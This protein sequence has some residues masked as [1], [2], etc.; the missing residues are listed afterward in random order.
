MVL[1]YL[2]IRDAFQFAAARLIEVA[3]QFAVAFL[4]GSEPIPQNEPL[5][6]LVGAVSTCG[7][8]PL[9]LVRRTHPL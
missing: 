7:S 4:I 9:A 5:G 6:K 3:V 8:C 2:M 1:C